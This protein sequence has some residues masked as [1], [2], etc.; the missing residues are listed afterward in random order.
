[1]RLDSNTVSERFNQKLND[2]RNLTRRLYKSETDSRM[3]MCGMIITL[4]DRD[5][6]CR[7][8]VI[9]EEVVT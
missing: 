5:D 3:N 4:N 6:C 2:G 1:M 9:D 7:H 8:V